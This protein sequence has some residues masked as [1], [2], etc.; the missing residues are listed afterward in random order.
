MNIIFTRGFGVEIPRS[1][2]LVHSYY[3]IK[4]GDAEIHTLSFNGTKVARYSEGAWALDIA[5]DM[6]SYLDYL[7]GSNL[8]GVSETKTDYGIDTIQTATKI[9]EKIHSDTTYYWRDHLND[10][11]GVDNCNTALHET[12]IE[13]NAAYQFPDV[14]FP[15][16]SCG[17]FMVRR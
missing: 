16:A 1:K 7:Q 12:M 10:L 14:W 15:P 6:D 17:D 2:L 4:R 9:L 8:W 13:Q 3:V 5:S 11:S